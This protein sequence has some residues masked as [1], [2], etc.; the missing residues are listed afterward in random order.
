MS[1][2]IHYKPERQGPPPIIPA[3]TEQL[4]RNGGKF[5]T[6]AEVDANGGRYPTKE[7]NSI[8]MPQI[9]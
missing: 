1:E 8:E 9:H 2:I 7:G 4:K 3:T 6:E 5:A